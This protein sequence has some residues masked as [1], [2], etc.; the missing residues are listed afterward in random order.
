MELNK[1]VDELTLD[2]GYIWIMVDKE[3]HY[4]GSFTDK[5]CAEAARYTYN[6]LFPDNA[7]FVVA[8]DYPL[9]FWDGASMLAE[10]GIEVKEDN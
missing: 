2:D 7:P 6:R 5:G 8:C 10:A 4:A 9:M 3:K 1:K